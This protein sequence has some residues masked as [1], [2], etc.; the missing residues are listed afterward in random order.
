MAQ[1]V[2]DG[3]S[4]STHGKSTFCERCVSALLKNVDLL[5]DPIMYLLHLNITKE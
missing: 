1:N 5:D 3:T 2:I 4:F